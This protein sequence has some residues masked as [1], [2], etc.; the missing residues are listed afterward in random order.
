MI[1]TQA[2]PVN[3]FIHFFSRSTEVSRLNKKPCDQKSQAR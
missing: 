3:P 1:L 2:Y